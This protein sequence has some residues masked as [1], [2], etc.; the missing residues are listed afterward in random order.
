MQK[1]DT[2]I[3][4]QIF[5]YWVELRDL[6]DRSVRELPAKVVQRILLATKGKR[7]R[8][9]ETE[10]DPPERPS[11]IRIVVQD[12]DRTWEALDKDD[13]SRQLRERYADGVF[14][15][16]LKCQRDPEAEE[17]HWA[18][19][20]ELI[21]IIARATVRRMLAEEAAKQTQGAPVPD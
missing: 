1:D 7:E 9:G 4:R 15:R 10:P 3:D 12:I 8:R 20:K 2:P 11:E 18:A 5:R 6:R 21:R 19:T 13:L 17:R 16:S 14:E